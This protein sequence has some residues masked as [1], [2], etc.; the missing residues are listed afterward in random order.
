MAASDQLAKLSARTKEA[1]TRVAAAQDKAKSD[2]EQ[3][4]SAAR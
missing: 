1:E 4:V 3:D 2:L